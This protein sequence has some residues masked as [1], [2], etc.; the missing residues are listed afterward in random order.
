MA[1]RLKY[2]LDTNIVS[3]LARNPKGYSAARIAEIGENAIAISVI[4]ASE[5]HF[6]LAKLEV[7][8]PDSRLIANL[9]VI[10]NELQIFPFES[11]ADQHYGQIRQHLE[12]AGRVIGPNDLLIAA[13]A[14]ALGYTLVTRNIREFERVPRLK[15]EN[16]PPLA[17]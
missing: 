5:L 12:R 17:G 8:N 2:L 13:H 3:D 10:L 4:V 7:S 11:P 1:T 9:R 6:G 14:R 16:W 15:V